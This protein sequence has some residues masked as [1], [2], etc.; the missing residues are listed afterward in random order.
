[1]T[2]NATFAHWRYIWRWFEMRFQSDFVR[3]LSVLTLT[4]DFTGSFE[5]PV[6]W[7][8]SDDVLSKV[9]EVHRGSWAGSILLLGFLHRDCLEGAMMDLQFSCL[10]V[11]KPRHPCTQSMMSL[12][13]QPMRIGCRCLD[14]QI[15]S[16]HLQITVRTVCV[17]DLIWE[18][19]LICLRF[20]QSRWQGCQNVLF[21]MA[22]SES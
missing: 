2:W 8:N 5:S 12:P 21:W 19:N 20:E 11:G 13:Q 15:W 6:P 22:K 18:A 17:K 14:T 16:D 10:H 1:M 9:T 4:A 3:C 7:Q